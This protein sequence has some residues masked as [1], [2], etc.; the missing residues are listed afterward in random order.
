MIVDFYKFQGTGND[1]IMIVDRG[2][3]FNMEDSVL[4]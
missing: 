1:F 2:V 3:E 4:I